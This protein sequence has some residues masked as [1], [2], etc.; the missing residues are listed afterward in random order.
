MA[1]LVV[2]VVVVV[3]VVNWQVLAGRAEE[4]PPA[5]WELGVG[6]WEG[7]HSKEHQWLPVFLGAQVRYIRGRQ[8]FCAQPALFID[9][10]CFDRKEDKTP[11]GHGRLE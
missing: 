1:L 6:S 9:C 11:G 3:V 7:T 4:K 5:S 2:V 10:C 8:T